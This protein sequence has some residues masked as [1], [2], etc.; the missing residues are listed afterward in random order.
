MY[1]MFQTFY[2]FVLKK[3]KRKKQDTPTYTQTPYTH[4]PTHKH[5]PHTIRKLNK[6]DIMIILQ[7]SKCMFMSLDQVVFINLSI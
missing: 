5:T 3:K 7:N 6:L 4:T 1:T 2:T